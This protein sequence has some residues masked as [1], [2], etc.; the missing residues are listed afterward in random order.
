MVPM[1]PV[2][3]TPS[4]FTTSRYLGKTFSLAKAMENLARSSVSSACFRNSSRSAEARGLL[5]PPGTAADGWT[6]QLW[7]RASWRR[8]G[9]LSPPLWQYP[10]PLAARRSH[11]GWNSRRP[12]RA[13]NRLQPRNRNGG[14]ALPCRRCCY[15]AREASCPRGVDRLQRLHRK[16]WPRQDDATTDIHRKC[17]A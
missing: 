14:C 17:A 10:A 6:C 15:T 11:C 16:P 12:D 4:D 1:K 7:F 3:I 9:A 2:L 13:E 8:G 5:N